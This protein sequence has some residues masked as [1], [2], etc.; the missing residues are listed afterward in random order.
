MKFSM[1][2]QENGDHMVRS[3]C[4]SWHCLL[5]Y[6]FLNYLQTTDE[7]WKPCIIKEAVTQIF[8]VNLVHLNI[9]AT[10]V[11]GCHPFCYEKIAA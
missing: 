10:V 6:N 4:L 5:D 2:G 9:T 11:L 8:K 7:N 1:I 3:N